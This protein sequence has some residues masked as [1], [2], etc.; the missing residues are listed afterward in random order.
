[1]TGCSGRR[2][3]ALPSKACD[4][5]SSPFPGV[6]LTLRPAANQTQAAEAS[7]ES[8]SEVATSLASQPPIH[9]WPFDEGVPVLLSQL[10]AHKLIGFSD[11]HARDISRSC[12]T[13]M[14]DPRHPSDAG[15]PTKCEIRIGLGLRWFPTGTVADYC[16]RVSLGKFR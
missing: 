15:F 3:I 7:S 9:A 5:D 12:F 13:P 4:G 10:P 1:M 11:E 2:S 14:S 16:L 8:R 6:L